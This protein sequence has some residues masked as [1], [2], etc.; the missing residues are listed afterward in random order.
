MKNYYNILGVDKSAS[1]EEIKHAYHKLVKGVHPDNEGFGLN[2]EEQKEYMCLLNEAYDV[3]SDAE[4]REEYDRILTSFAEDATEQS[5]KSDDNEEDS[6]E[7]TQSNN[8]DDLSAN[9]VPGVSGTDRRERRNSRSIGSKISDIVSNIIAYAIIIAIIVAIGNHFHLFDKIKGW[10]STITHKVESINVE[11]LEEDSPEHCVKQYLNYL[12]QGESQKALKCFVDGKPYKKMTK[13]ITQLYKGADV[14][15]L[16]SPIVKRLQ[17][18]DCEI[19]NV[20]TVGNKAKVK[21]I[22]ENI[23][24]NEVMED[25]A[26]QMAATEEYDMGYLEKLVNDEDY[27]IKDSFV[28]EVERRDDVWLITTIDRPEELGNILIGNMGV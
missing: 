25:M 4:K 24:A 2:S 19:D 3:L 16:T 27:N 8:N 28:I 9:D 6:W 13:Y 22:I 23:D 11:Y 20:E 5:V 18:F 12:S 14:E 10:F 21:I 1:F 7:S 15:S 26:Y 17:K